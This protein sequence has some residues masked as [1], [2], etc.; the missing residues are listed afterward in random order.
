MSVAS[1]LETAWR[2]RPAT[3]EPRRVFHGPGEGS[4]RLEDLFIDVFGDHAWVT[5]K[6]AGHLET[7]RAIA[8]FLESKGLQSAVVQEKPGDDLATLAGPL[9]GA[10]PERFV[11]EEHGLKY[12]IRLSGTRHPGL[13]L[14]HA[15]LRAWLTKNF[16]GASV[17]NTFCYTGSLSV[18]A[19]AARPG[20]KI[21]NLDLSKPAIEWSRQNWLLNGHREED[22]DFI[23]GDVFEWL[24]KLDKRG[25]KFDCVLVDPPS[26]SH[27]KKGHFSTK[28]NLKELA[29]LAMT[30]VAPGGLL[31]VSINSY[32]VSWAEFEKS[33]ATASQETGFKGR[34]LARIGQ[35][36]T[37]YPV[38][39]PEDRYLKG[40]LLQS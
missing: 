13:F 30:L 15:P 33:L 26:S 37:Y 35:D 11:C 22:G 20:V 9:F 24:P 10:P 25:R 6:G 1:I 18:A 29:V 34:E 36:E 28:K 38:R 7:N 21:T 31:M 16:G 27:G 32:N 8:S 3:R 5:W 19:A 17:L 14:D 23:Y 40:L 2:A 12:E 39:R 4:G